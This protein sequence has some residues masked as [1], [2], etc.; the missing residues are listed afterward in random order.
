M[1]FTT[2]LDRD[3]AVR[4][5]TRIFRAYGYS[6]ATPVLLAHAVGVAKSDLYSAFGSKHDLFLT[7]LTTYADREFEEFS[8]QLSKAGPAQERIRRA[9][10]AA[11][12]ADQDDPDHCGCLIVSTATERG[13]SDSEASKIVWES[14][15]RTRAALRGVLAD[16]VQA[17]EI[18]LDRDLDALADMLQCTMIGLRVLGS[19]ASNSASIRAVIDSAVS[20]I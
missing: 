12:A 17:G 14:M 2:T 4:A 16:G 13:F 3:G 5:A 7:C 1:E 9:F 11:A 15:S 6:D 19:A 20:N 10:D 18:D 8:E